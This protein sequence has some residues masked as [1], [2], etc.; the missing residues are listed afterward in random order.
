MSYACVYVM[1][2]NNTTYNNCHRYCNY[3]YNRK[4]ISH[5]ANRRRW[6]PSTGCHH[7]VDSISDVLCN[8]RSLLRCLFV[9][10]TRHSEEPGCCSQP[11]NQPTSTTRVT[12][13]VDK[14]KNSNSELHNFNFTAISVPDIS[15]KLHFLLCVS[16]YRTRDLPLRPVDPT[17]KSKSM[18]RWILRNVWL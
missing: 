8:S 17:K 5:L 15:R 12:Y 13:T 7:I 14:T 10:A 18:L 4:N 16:F 3:Y 9:S 6:F 11:L 1:S 2:W